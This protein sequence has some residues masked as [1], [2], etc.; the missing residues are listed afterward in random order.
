[1]PRPCKQRR[2]C[3]MPGCL[4][5]GPVEGGKPELPPIAMAVD[6]F[7][8]IRLID[9]EGLTQEACA[10]RMN[11]ARTTAQAIYAGARSKVAECLVTGRELTIQGGAYVL[12]DGAAIGCGHA[13]ARRRCEALEEQYE[14]ENPRNGRRKNMRIAVTYENGTVFQHFGHAEQFKLYDVESGAVRVS[15]VVET[16]GSGHG[17]LAAFLKG[18]GVDVLICGGIGGGAQ[19]ALAE[20]G[21][22][23][24]GGVSGSADA[25]VQALLDGSLAYNP[26]VQCNHHGEGHG[27]GEAGH[28]CGHHG[29]GQGHSCGGHG[30]CSNH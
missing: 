20:A 29:E 13:C 10:A 8:A 27:H 9:Y 11:V 15:M 7:E 24:Y 6:E 16:N 25:A 12:C 28:S 3:A 1:M 26:N 17:A 4:R 5:F 2:V 18:N 22:K 19:T 14:G 23:L 30:G 21:V